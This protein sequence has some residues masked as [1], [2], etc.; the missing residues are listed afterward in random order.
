MEQAF[1]SLE[2]VWLASPEQLLALPGVGPALLRSRDQLLLS[3]A[4]V[5]WTVPPRVLLPTDPA[6]PSVLMALPQ[7]P[8][9]L[10][11]RGRGALWPLLR[12]QQAVAV[13]GSRRGS[14]YGCSWAQRLGQ[15]LARAGWPVIS[16]LAEGVDAQAHQG[17]LQ[18]G[19]RPIAVLGTSLERVYPRH[20]R[21]L[22][23]EV[24]SRGLLISE[25][26]PGA[27][28][29]KGAFAQRN[30]LLVALAQA[31]VLVECPR[32][33]GALQAAEI[34]WSLQRPIWVVP[35]DSDRESAAGSNG[36]LN[37][38]ATAL[39]ETAQLIDALGR[40]PLH[41]LAP[42]PVVASSR[43]LV[44]L[45]SGASF[46]EL[47][48]RL[49]LSPG[50]LAKQLLAHEQQGSIEALSGL[51]WRPRHTEIDLPVALQP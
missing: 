24:S 22:Q 3:R 28:G 51:C 43:L 31:V 19:G 7:P 13:I 41:Q 11:W 12:R 32:R 34:A 37:R 8:A 49:Q 26:A 50:A 48:L 36:W 1:G 6:M 10:F 16:G 23:A 2:A 33:S 44:A 47:Q 15:A 25:Q 38:G 21:Q 46:E 9:S 27:P 29:L 4:P 20:H 45:G 18:A 40:G 17:C 5:P 14:P 35:A 42:P 39:L 30:R